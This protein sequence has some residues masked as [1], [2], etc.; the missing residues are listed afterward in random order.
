MH[1]LRRGPSPHG[2][3]VDNDR[4]P[5]NAIRGESGGKGGRCDTAKRELLVAVE[6]LGDS[7]DEIGQDL[8]LNNDISL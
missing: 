5:V 1:H 7:C 4:S 2:C 6:G 8:A 3:R